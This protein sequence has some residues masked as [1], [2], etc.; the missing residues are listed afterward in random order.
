MDG[1]TTARML[2][3][4]PIELA[5]ASSSLPWPFAKQFALHI[6]PWDSGRAWLRCAQAGP[7]LRC[8]ARAIWS[9]HLVA[10]R[11][12]RG[13][14]VVGGVDVCRPSWLRL[15]DARAWGA[16]LTCRANGQTV[17]P[18]NKAAATRS[19]PMSNASSCAPLLVRLLGQSS[20]ST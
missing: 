18:R 8:A 1:R 17:V 9:S 6:S 15:I 3:C 16:H 14:V 19:S 20:Y 5:R 7:S 11:K 12:R 2:L 10:R 4:S 13:R